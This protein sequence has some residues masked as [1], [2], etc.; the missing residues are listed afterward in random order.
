[1]SEPLAFGFQVLSC[2]CIGGLLVLEWTALRTLMQETLILNHL[3]RPNKEPRKGNE[4]VLGARVQPFHVAR[5]DT[6][7]SF[8]EK[9]LL[10][11]VTTLLF[12][13]P[14]EL[15]SE[16]ESMFAQLLHSVWTKRQGPIY[17]VCSKSRGD[18]Q[19][20][21]DRFQFGKSR[22]SGIDLLFDAEGT[23]ARCARFFRSPPQ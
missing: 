18:C 23:M 14:N 2:V 5:L 11:N 16:T 1:M 7:E 21:A 13:A 12:V 22:G 9:D 6:E 15:A 4:S 3:F 20:V 19:R 10:E 17:V 8:T